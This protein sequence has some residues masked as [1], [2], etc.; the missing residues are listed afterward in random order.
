MWVISIFIGSV[1]LSILWFMERTKDLTFST[2]AFQMLPVLILCEL[3]YWYG[4][5][6]APSFLTARYLMSSIT[7][8]LGLLL[9]FF[10]LK[11]PF[12]IKQGI[13]II[14][15]VVGIIILK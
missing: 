1:L 3:F 10:F 15:I 14:F 4:F 12:T 13:G 6:K 5:R 7:H 2:W 11:E 8:V 9:V